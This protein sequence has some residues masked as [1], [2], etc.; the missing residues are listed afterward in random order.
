MPWRINQKGGCYRYGH[1]YPLQKRVQ[2][3]VT[4]LATLSIAFTARLCRVTYS[5]VEKYI[6]QFQQKA[7]FSPALSDNTRPKKIAWWM[8]AYIEALDKKCVSNYFSK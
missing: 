5:C 6:R 4:Y 3:I 8:E 1:S 2:I 7:S